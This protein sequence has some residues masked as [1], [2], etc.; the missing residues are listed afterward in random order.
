[1]SKLSS[2]PVIFTGGQAPPFKDSMTY[3]RLLHLLARQQAHFPMMQSNT[4]CS[5]FESAFA[6]VKDFWACLN[7]PAQ[8]PH[9]VTIPN[10]LSAA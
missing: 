4:R 9:E 10:Y 1:M 8:T 2:S 7:A 6:E 3:A 5:A